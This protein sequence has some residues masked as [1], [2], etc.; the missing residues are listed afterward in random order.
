MEMRGDDP[1]QIHGTIHGSGY[2]GGGSV[3]GSYVLADGALFSDDFHTFTVDYEPERIAWYVDGELY[4]S[5]SP[6]DLPEG[7]AWSHDGP[8]FMILNLAVGGN[9]LED[10]DETTEF[11]ASV[12][13]DWVRVYERATPY[14]V[15]TG[16]VE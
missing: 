15:D 7:S 16:A 3:G 9:Y 2:F 8:V 11:P 10:P 13:V 1:T 6:G 14:P 5:R 4:Q 12:E